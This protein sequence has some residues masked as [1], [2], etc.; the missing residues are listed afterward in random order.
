MVSED[1]VGHT[2]RRHPFVEEKEG[3]KTQKS[4]H[5]SEIQL[6]KGGVLR[7]GSGQGPR[8]VVANAVSWDTG[9][10]HPQ[11]ATSRGTRE[12]DIRS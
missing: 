9:R 4:N 1:L 3:N 5:T 7:Q 6:G 2:R 11:L 8:S 10:N 12:G